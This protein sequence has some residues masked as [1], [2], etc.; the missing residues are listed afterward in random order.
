MLNGNGMYNNITMVA[1][2]HGPVEVRKPRVCWRRMRVWCGPE[3]CAFIT[4]ALFVVPVIVFLFA[5]VFALPLWAIECSQLGDECRSTTD[6]P[7]AGAAHG[8]GRGLSEAELAACGIS[9]HACHYWEWFLYIASNLLGLATP[10]TNVSPDS[11]HIFAEIID[12]IIAVWSLSIAGAAIGVVSALTFTATSVAGLETALSRRFARK[13]L[14][15]AA[16]ESGKL[17]LPR[18]REILV[19]SGF[20]LTDTQAELVF[21]AADE[22]GSHYL[23]RAEVRKISAI[24]E[25]GGLRRSSTDDTHAISI[26]KELKSQRL[27]LAEL[28]TEIRKLTYSSQAVRTLTDV[29]SIPLPSVDTVSSSCCSCSPLSSTCW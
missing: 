4:I 9:R 5:M 2:L 26:S 24:L 23:D 1:N 28:K 15:A 3:F 6:Q 27:L 18:M 10:L 19:Q 20:D 21:K 14:E 25:A 13:R 7:G 8:H 16:D 29:G 22:D 17:D 12:L 11:G